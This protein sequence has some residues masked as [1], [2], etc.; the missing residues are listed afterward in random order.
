[1]NLI[2]LAPPPLTA[3]FCLLLVLAAAEDTL[4]RTISNWTSGAV[5]VCA[6]AVMVFADWHVEIWQNALLALMVL[7]VGTLLFGMGKMGGGDVKLFSAVA[8]W[9]SLSGA[10]VLIPAILIAGGL[11]GALVLTR[12][13]ILRSVSS[14]SGA[15]Y[16]ASQGVP[17]GA[18]IA[19]GALF[20]VA[21]QAHI[22]ADRYVRLTA[23][24][25][26]VPSGGH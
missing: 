20:T 17:Y 7:A 4:R 11:L 5:L 24:P 3:V 2:A 9:T 19:A 14:R 12:R 26:S 18:A 6:L 21:L 22:R 23:A 15:V 16:R 8:L 13:A 25:I 1:V 10:V